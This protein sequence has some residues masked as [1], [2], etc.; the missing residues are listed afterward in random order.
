MIK[1]LTKKEELV[2]LSIHHLEEN[3]YLVAIQNHLAEVTGKRTF[4]PS[5]HLT[6]NRLE[7]QQLLSAQMKGAS[8]VRG[9]RRK[10]IYNLTQ[11]GHIHLDECKRIN[12]ILWEN[13]QSFSSGKIK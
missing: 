1:I 7:E 10:K 13:Y 5:L 4:L 8:S 9:G 12:N 11:K 6:L 2:M 3:A